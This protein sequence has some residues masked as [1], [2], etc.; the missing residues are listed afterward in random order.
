M[1]RI[2]QICHESLRELVPRKANINLR[3]HI[4]NFSVPLA[5][6]KKSRSIFCDYFKIC[7]VVTGWFLSFPIVE[8]Q[9]RGSR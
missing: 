1:K 4:Y 8:A 3:I 7:S 9:I 5:L 2:D 6:E